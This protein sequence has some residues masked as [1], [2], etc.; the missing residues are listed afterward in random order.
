MQ[1]LGNELCVVIMTFS[2]QD[3]AWS[4]F[5]A[6][7][8]RKRDIVYICLERARE[9]EG[10]R[11]ERSVMFGCDESSASWAPAGICCWKDNKGISPGF[12]R[13]FGTKRECLICFLYVNCSNS[14]MPLSIAWAQ[15]TQEASVLVAKKHRSSDNKNK[16]L[17]WKRLKHTSMHTLSDSHRDTRFPISA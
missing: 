2:C 4:K 6:A 11:G 14:W 3:A 9:R 5:C 1:G 7:V 10:E 8:R 13:A 15:Q 17:E 16:D 12:S